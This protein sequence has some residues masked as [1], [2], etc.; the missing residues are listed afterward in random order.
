[1]EVL[2]LLKE[3]PAKLTCERGTI[4]G[5]TVGYL[6]SLARVTMVSKSLLPGL[7]YKS[8]PHGTF[9]AHSYVNFNTR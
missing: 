2:A 7:G 8:V 3:S 4:D 1:M 5:L 6:V 9:Y